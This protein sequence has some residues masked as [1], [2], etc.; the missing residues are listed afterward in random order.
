[1]PPDEAAFDIGAR[2]YRCVARA[3][4]GPAPTTSQFLR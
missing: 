1:M 3:L 2:A 4:T